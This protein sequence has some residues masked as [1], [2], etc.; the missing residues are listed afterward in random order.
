MRRIAAAA[1][2]FC[3]GLLP[4]AATAALDL[5]A[6]IGGW[7]GGLGRLG[8]GLSDGLGRGIGQ[9]LGRL[10][11]RYL[12]PTEG[13]TSFEEGFQH[14]GLGRMVLFI[15]PEVPSAT[16]APV[17][18]LLHYNGGTRSDIANMTHIADLAR[19]FG[20]W[21]IVP[22]GVSQKWNDDPASVRPGHDDVG[23]LAQVIQSAAARHPIDP[24][25]VY[26][27][28]MSNGGFM[29]SRF[30]C[31]RPDLIAAGASVAATMRQGLNASC[32]PSRAV[33]M[34]FML[35]TSDLEVSYSRTSKWALLS[36]P[37]TLQRWLGI[38]GCNPAQVSS[39][40]LPNL[41]PKDNT[42]TDVLRSGSCSSGGAVEMYV[43]KGGGHT[44]P[45]GESGYTL[46][47]GRTAKDF[48]GT[49]AAWTFFER[50]QLP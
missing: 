24:K 27:A 6:I 43:V 19:D 18:V 17:V 3:V 32:N 21:I 40:P 46:T 11:H 49:L 39:T 25:R 38:H 5:G 41:D 44:W 4:G 47:L 50:F 48:S 29:T 45:Q 13:T 30:A 31:E 42:T 28:G 34:T 10:S 14:Q 8:D 2:A 22:E 16:P 23:F 7:S 9:S 37:D 12:F 35:G 15:R 20:A 36:G 1:L 26:M 33:P